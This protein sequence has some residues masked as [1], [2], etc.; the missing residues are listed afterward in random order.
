MEIKDLHREYVWIGLKCCVRN[1]RNQ[2]KKLATCHIF[3]PRTQV[4]PA[5]LSQILPAMRDSVQSGTGESWFVW[6]TLF[7]NL[8]L[9]ETVDT[10]G[11]RRMLMIER[12]GPIWFLKTCLQLCL[13]I[14]RHHIFPYVHFSNFHRQPISY[15][16]FITPIVC[17]SALEIYSVPSQNLC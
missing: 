3:S 15:F 1:T 16:R 10:Q 17:L 2:N 11:S 8:D 5:V 12:K 7:L 4:S 14:C 6:E 13:S 9:Q